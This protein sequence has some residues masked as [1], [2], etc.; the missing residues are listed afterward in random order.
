MNIQRTV[1]ERIAKLEIEMTICRVKMEECT[2]EKQ[3]ILD[4]YLK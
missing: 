4:K 1:A 2:V 3:K